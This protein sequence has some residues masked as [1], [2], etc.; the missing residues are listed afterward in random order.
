V[1]E[2]ALTLGLVFLVGGTWGFRKLDPQK[3]FFAWTAAVK[4]LI[5]GRKVHYWQTI[6]SGA[7]VYT[8]HLMPEVRDFAELEK[9]LG[10]EDR[11][12]TMAREWNEDLHGL[13]A[14]RRGEFEVLLRMPSGGGELLLLKRQA[15]V[16]PHLPPVSPGDPGPRAR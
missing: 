13:N 8:D 11:L 16:A 10:P 12:V 2:T 14:A 7:M 5:A 6:R 4:P 15:P 9:R 1:R 3:N